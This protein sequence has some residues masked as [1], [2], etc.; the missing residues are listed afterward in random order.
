[1]QSTDSIF[2]CAATHAREE[3][4]GRP[5]A[6]EQ[7]HE[8]RVVAEANIL[9]RTFINGDRQ[10]VRHLTDSLDQTCSFFLHGETKARTLRLANGL[11]ALYDLFEDKDVRNRTPEGLHML[12]R[13]LQ[14]ISTLAEHA[15]ERVDASP[16]GEGGE[17]LGKFPAVVHEGARAAVTEIIDAELDRLDFIDAALKMSAGVRRNVAS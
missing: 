5:A 4:A 17:M 9:T 3:E 15:Q 14:E 1:M 11:A 16:P 8:A 7:G 12:A 13:K 2:R 6:P 10:E